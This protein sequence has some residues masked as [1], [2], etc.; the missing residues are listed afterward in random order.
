MLTTVP[1]AVRQS[2]TISKNLKICEMGARDSAGC[3]AMVP[4]RDGRE[5]LCRK[6]ASMMAAA[7]VLL[8]AVKTALMELDVNGSARLSDYAISSLRRAVALAVPQ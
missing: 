6:R 4:L 3:I 1:W 2:N 5:A 7:P 8:D